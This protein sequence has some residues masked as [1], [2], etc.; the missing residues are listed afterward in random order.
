MK[1]IV[2]DGRR[3]IPMLRMAAPRPARAGSLSGLTLLA[4]E[5][6]RVAAEGLRQI[7]RA[8]GARL[9]RAATLAEAERHLSL[10]CP[11]AILIDLGLPDG[12][13]EALVASLARAA[14]RPPAIIAMSGEPDR[15]AAA[16]A[17]GADAFL[18][19]PVPSAQAL[20]TTVLA[21]LPHVACAA[22]PVTDPL[23]QDPL[24]LADD[25]AVAADLLAEGP[26][27]PLRAYLA[28]FL[29]GVAQ[30]TG[31]NVLCNV[32]EDFGRG[33]DAG[34]LSRL[35]ADRRAMIDAF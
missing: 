14:R 1:D 3:I 34:L 33:A 6:S 30:Q 29:S 21:H 4:V 5:D 32:A 35:I 27:A 17:C 19:K 8:Q 20:T 22:R 28:T 11:D 16:L 12:R 25:L 24:A 23:P 26:D 18:A 13:G 10:Y 2:A 15:G 7:C 9:R 31:D